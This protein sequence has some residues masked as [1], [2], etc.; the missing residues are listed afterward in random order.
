MNGV[1]FL[2]KTDVLKGVMYFST[3]ESPQLFPIPVEKVKELIALNKKGEKMELHLDGEDIDSEFKSAVGEDSLTR[4]D[5]TQKNRKNKKGG[6]APKN[7][8]SGNNNNNSSNNNR[9]PENSKNK[10]NNR[11]RNNNKRNNN[12]N[13]NNA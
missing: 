10:Q 9:N 8:G 12:A 6:G 5:R 13:K 1:I 2:Q 3:A 11:R 7:P 4:F